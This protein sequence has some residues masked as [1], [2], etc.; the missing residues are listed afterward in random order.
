MKCY[1]PICNKSGEID[2]IC[3]CGQKKGSCQDHN[4]YIKYEIKACAVGWACIICNTSPA[5]LGRNQLILVEPFR[6]GCY[7]CCHCLVELF[8]RII[9]FDK[10]PTKCPPLVECW[11]WTQQID[12]L[13]STI[14]DPLPL[15]GAGWRFTELND[16]YDFCQ[17]CIN[18]K[19][20]QKLKWWVY[21]LKNEW[22]WILII[23]C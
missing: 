5:P 12:F 19:V 15:H 8:V 4:D 13:P 3:H 21:K 11:N 2:Y 18:F 1:I 14:E 10:A 6:I 22:K 23:S 17:Y 16:H 20:E 9:Q 7:L